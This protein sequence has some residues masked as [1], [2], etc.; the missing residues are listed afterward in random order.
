M[1]VALTL[2][3]AGDGTLAGGTY[4]PSLEIVP[5]DVPVQPVPLTVQVSAAFDVPVTFPTNC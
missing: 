1:L 4:S 3:V 5:H 2:T